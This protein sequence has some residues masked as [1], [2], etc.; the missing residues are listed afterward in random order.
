[1]IKV[2][3]RIKQ[4]LLCR[5]FLRKQQPGTLPNLGHDRRSKN[6]G[7]MVLSK[8]CVNR[9]GMSCQLDCEDLRRSRGVS[10]GCFRFAGWRRAKCGRVDGRA[11]GGEASV[12]F[13]NLSASEQAQEQKAFNQT[14]T[15]IRS[16]T[17]E[18]M[19]VFQVVALGAQE[20]TCLLH[21]FA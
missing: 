11:D 4:H 16:L 21:D 14:S 9:G 12:W 1:M 15:R 5:L 18:Q 6:G 2:E 8:G 13:L 10:R 19:L 7:L 3:E 17:L 20:Y